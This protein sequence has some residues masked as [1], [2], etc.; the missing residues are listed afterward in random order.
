MPDFVI[1]DWWLE[2]NEGD[3]AP[4]HVHHDAEEGFIN[5]EGDLEVE[6]DGSRHDVQPGTFVV[7]PRGS[8]H[9][10]R[11]RRGAHVLAVMSPDVAALIDDLHQPMN[12]EQKAAVWRRHRS[13]LA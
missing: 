11:T 5:I 1:S 4:P 3:Q 13:S 6:V 10:F 2:G 9:T 7:V 12:D 8:V